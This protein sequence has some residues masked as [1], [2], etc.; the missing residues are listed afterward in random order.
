MG[1][2]EKGQS[3]ATRT[4][5]LLSR[6]H[7]GRLRSLSCPNRYRCGDQKNPVGSV[8]FVSGPGGRRGTLAGVTGSSTAATGSSAAA[9]GSSAAAARSLAIRSEGVAARWTAFATASAC[10]A[11]G[12]GSSAAHSSGVGKHS[13]CLR[14]AGAACKPRE[15][16]HFVSWQGFPSMGGA[17]A[18]ARSGR[19]CPPQSGFPRD[20]ACGDGAEVSTWWRAASVAGDGPSWPTGQALLPIRKRRSSPDGLAHQLRA[21]LPRSTG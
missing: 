19:R 8:R 7:P 2:L 3:A 18:T 1:L 21:A 12:R 4:E 14:A 6:N 9:T 20:L 10:S 11:P 13:G 5:L 17:T 16:R 15:P